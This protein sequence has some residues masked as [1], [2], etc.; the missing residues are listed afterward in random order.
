MKTKTTPGEIIRTYRVQQ[1]MTLDTFAK[2]LHCTKSDLSLVE[3][4]KKT[5]SNLRRLFWS[6]IIPQF[7]PDMLTAEGQKPA[8]G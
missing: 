1:G 3:N 2:V 4:N 5:I 7:T 6:T 8:D